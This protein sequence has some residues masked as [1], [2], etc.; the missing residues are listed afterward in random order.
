LQHHRKNNR[1]AGVGEWVEHRHRSRERGEWDRG[2]PEGKNRK[3]IYKYIKYPI[4]I[5]Y[6]A[7]SMFY[8]A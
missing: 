8:I 7:S 4:K 1:E 5:M 2:L 6:V 3:Y